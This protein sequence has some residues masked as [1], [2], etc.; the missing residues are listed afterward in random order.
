MHHEPI[1][2][3]AK[4]RTLFRLARALARRPARPTLDG[5]PWRISTTALLTRSARNIRAG[6]RKAFAA[7]AACVR[8]K[9]NASERSHRAD[10][11]GRKR[12]AFRVE[13]RASPILPRNS[14]VC[15]LGLP[16][17]RVAVADA[18][19]RACRRFREAVLRR[20]RVASCGITTRRPRGGGSRL[21]ASIAAASAGYDCPPAGRLDLLKRVL[22]PRR[23]RQDPPASCRA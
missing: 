9:K 10:Y 12:S 8:M 16:A 11:T 20:G 17:L 21:C 5:C 22:D 15:L 6:P 3:H 4:R 14:A 18:H 1:T 23:G 19:G 7:R 13:M 2:V